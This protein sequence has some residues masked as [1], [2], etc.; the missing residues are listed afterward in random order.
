MSYSFS[1]QIVQT[2]AIEATVADYVNDVRSTSM[3]DTLRSFRQRA[4]L[5]LE[6]DI[7][8]DDEQIR[9]DL[10]QATRRIREDDDSFDSD[11]FLDELERRRSGL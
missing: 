5:A 3:A 11:A 7:Y 2:Q 9:K 10:H 4:L 1:T 6:D 8:D